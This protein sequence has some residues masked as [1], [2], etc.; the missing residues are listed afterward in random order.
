MDLR[1]RILTA[2]Y[3]H[4][5]GH[6]EKHVVNIELML[7]HPAG[8]AEHPDYLDTIQ[9]ELKLIAE[10]DDQIEVLTNYLGYIPSEDEGSDPDPERMPNIMSIKY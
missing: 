3:N 5:Q 9:S 4:L 2:L 7:A 1:D 6:I 10:Y 8:V